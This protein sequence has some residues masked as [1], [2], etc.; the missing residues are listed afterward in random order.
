MYNSKEIRTTHKKNLLQTILKN[1]NEDHDEI[2]T[3]REKALSFPT[4]S[5]PTTNKPKHILCH[6]DKTN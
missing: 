1:Y 6:S 3:V 2:H 4:L 5:I